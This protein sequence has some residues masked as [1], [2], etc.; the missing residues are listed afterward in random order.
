[1][2]KR[3]I[4]I[5]LTFCLLLSLTGCSFLSG[6]IQNPVKFYYQ[7]AEYLYGEEDAVIAAEERDG[8][9]HI[10]DM[11]YL[12]RL[13]LMG[14]HDEELVSPFPRGLLITD[15]RQGNG[16]VILTLTDSLSALPEHRQTLAC[17]CLALTCMD[18]FGQ[19]SVTLIWED[20]IRT[21]DR[22]VLTIFDDST[23]P[24]Q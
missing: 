18:M 17:A 7:R 12:L 19:D 14:P 9:G 23:P 6:E 13:Y 4:A 24:D 8:T 2:K 3:F 15:I 20:E 16:A 22:S 10:R 5:L 11:A 21:L 1:M